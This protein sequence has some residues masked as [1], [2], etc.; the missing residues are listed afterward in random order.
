[1]LVNFQAGCVHKCFRDGV[2][3]LT[4]MVLSRHLSNFSGSLTPCGLLFAI[5]S[6]QKMQYS[7]LEV[8]NSINFLE[9]T[10]NSYIPLK[11]IFSFPRKILL[12]ATKGQFY[13]C[14][15]CSFYIRKFCAQLFVLEF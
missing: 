12:I 8:S 2:I 7:Q 10:R 9:A 15:T 11:A 14:S 3:T 1:M 13:Q 5:A 6:G 4:P